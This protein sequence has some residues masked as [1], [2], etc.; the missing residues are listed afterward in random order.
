MQKERTL[1]SFCNV[2]EYIKNNHPSF[3]LIIANFYSLIAN[4]LSYLHCLYAQ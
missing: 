4:C 2:L 3:I 1:Y